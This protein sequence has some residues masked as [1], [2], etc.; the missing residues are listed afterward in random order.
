MKHIKKCHIFWVCLNPYIFY[1]RSGSSFCYI[2]IVSPIRVFLKDSIRIRFWYIRFHKAGRYRDRTKINSACFDI[3]II[4]IGAP[5]ME[6]ILGGNL[7]IGAR[8]Y[9]NI[10]HWIRCLNRDNCKFWIFSRK[11][12]FPS[13]LRNMFWVTI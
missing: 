3:L 8:V 4:K 1:P 13:H 10:D 5:I 2:M 6:L 11:Y 12:L 7:E 9:S